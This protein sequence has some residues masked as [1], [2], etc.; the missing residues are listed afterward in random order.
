M[1][2]VT[3]T[4]FTTNKQTNKKK[5][6]TEVKPLSKVSGQTVVTKGPPKRT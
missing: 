1:G 2:I 4:D 6:G 3:E 5:G